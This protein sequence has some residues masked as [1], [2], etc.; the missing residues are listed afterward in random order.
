VSEERYRFG[1]AGPRVD[2][3]PRVD[4]VVA[5]VT[6]LARFTVLAI[7]APS[8]AA[9]MQMHAFTDVLLAVAVYTAVAGYG[10]VLIWLTVRDHTLPLWTMVADVALTAVA[11]AVLPSAV[12]EHYLAAAPNPDLEPLMVTVGVTVALVTASVTGT[13]AAGSALAA[14]YAIGLGTQIST[15]AEVTSMVAPIL[16]MAST[17][18]CSCVFVRGLRATADAVQTA[19]QQL[20]AQREQLAAERA[21]TEARRRHFGEQLRRHRALHDGPLRILTAIAGP[22]PLGH[23]DERVRRQ[24]AIAANVLRGTTPDHP[25]ST[26][27][28]LSLALIE[29]AGDTTAGGLRVEYHFAGLPDDLPEPVV[30]AF[31]DASA[32]A[33]SNVATHAG[34]TRARLTALAGINDTGVTVAVV[35]QGKGFDAA[36]TPLGYGLQHS[37]IGRMR[38]VGGDASLDSHPGQGTR[39]DLRWPA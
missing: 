28:D 37:V 26:L 36:E 9:G 32:E 27:T 10:V 7:V 19:N 39:V 34:T 33:L 8:V 2:L 25:R 6:V 20:M 5:G 38:E 29:A 12:T 14:G 24:C 13:V 23:P 22:G 17:A 21:D 31:A 1:G 35:D 15:G 16:W 18:G 3:H 4:R 11:V 30:R